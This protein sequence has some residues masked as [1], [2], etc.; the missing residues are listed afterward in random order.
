MDNFKPVEAKPMILATSAMFAILTFADASKIRRGAEEELR[1][2]VG[3][4][5]RNTN[6]GYRRQM[7]K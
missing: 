6:A 3:A 4:N 5:G 2:N 1:S 7:V